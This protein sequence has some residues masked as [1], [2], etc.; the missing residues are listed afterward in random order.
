MVCLLHRYFG[1]LM[2]YRF[3]GGKTKM[4][5]SVV[6]AVLAFS[7]ALL[8]GSIGA[9]G[10]ADVAEMK[11]MLAER[12]SA[13]EKDAAA[14]TALLRR[15]QE[16]AQFCAYCH[17]K[18][19][20]SVKPLVPNLAGQN[21]NYLLDQIER[22]ASGKREDFIMTPL[23]R[24]YGPEDRIAVAVF[25]SSMTPTVHEADP[26]LVAQ[27]RARFMERCIGCHG[28]DAHGGEN[29]ARL[30]GQNARY[31]KHRLFY[32]QQPQSLTKVAPTIM[33]S[34]AKELSDDDIEAVAAFLTSHP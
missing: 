33:N 5:K 18:D 28:T 6:S 12:I 10:A 3:P 21:P 29:Y 11:R 26:N 8:F 30:A 13:K 2:V 15:G 14:W 24:Q 7:V 16:Q 23:A 27:G 1:Y 17:G 31:I 22:F 9:S 32:Y 4:R 19:G 34:V 20:I 25:F